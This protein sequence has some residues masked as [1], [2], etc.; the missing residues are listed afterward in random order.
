MIES[1]FGVEFDIL[2]LP[3]ETKK[4]ITEIR[5][6]KI[7]S[8]EVNY[9]MTDVVVWAVNVAD[10]AAKLEARKFASENGDKNANPGRE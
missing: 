10:H 8:G 3:K 2:S 4:K 9:T 6:N 7:K 1:H 5:N